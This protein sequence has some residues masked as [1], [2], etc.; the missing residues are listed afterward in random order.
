MMGVDW[1]TS[2]CNPTDIVAICTDS[3]SLCKALD[4]CSP[5]ITTLQK[6]LAE[7]PAEVIFQ[8]IPGH[9]KIPGNEAADSAA[10]AA[11]CLEEHPGEI[12]YGSICSLIDRSMIDPP[13][14]HDRT[15][16]VY[17]A[18]TKYSDATISSRA[19]QV[20]LAQLRS[21]HHMAFR[22]YRNRVY[23]DEDPKCPLCEEPQHTLEH[24]LLKCPGVEAEKYKIFGYLE[25]G[26]NVLITHPQES[27][28][29]SQSLL[30]GAKS[31][32]PSRSTSTN[33]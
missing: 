17:T 21:G 23:P 9:S 28:A 31:K 27:L 5:A 2:T 6:K 4:G 10:K 15:K 30:C 19:D 14:S 3:K 8:W 29:L 32:K 12:S 33:P 25:V 16:Q 26:L 22:A 20:L 24:W 11:T 1:T 18:S 13:M 7:C